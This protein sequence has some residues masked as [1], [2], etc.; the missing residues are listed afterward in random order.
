MIDYDELLAKLIAWTVETGGFHGDRQLSD[1]LL[2]ATGWKVEQDPTFQGGIRWYFGVNP[3]VSSSESQRPH[4]IHDIG[5]A[6]AARPYRWNISFTIVMEPAFLS[7]CHI[8]PSGRPPI[9]GFMGASKESE[10][11]AVMISVV[12]AWQS[13]AKGAA[14]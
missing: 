13:L 6:I 2:L 12:K 8:W 5:T 11:H 9:E 4:L 3:Q 14:G 10:P 7:V 1:E